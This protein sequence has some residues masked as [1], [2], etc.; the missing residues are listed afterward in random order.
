MG[1]GGLTRKFRLKGAEIIGTWKKKLCNEELHDLYFSPN[2][3]RVII[4]ENEMGCACGK[5]P[6]TK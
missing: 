5:S 3:I 2:V 6:L 4:M 1:G